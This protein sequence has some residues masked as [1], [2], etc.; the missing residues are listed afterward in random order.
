MT[1]TSDSQSAADRKLLA[2]DEPVPFRVLNP[3]SASRLLLLCD[4]A[5]RRI[6]A[7]LGSM[8]LDPAA[9]RC[10]LAWDIGAGA[11]TETLAKRL[12]ATAVL[13]NYSRLVV[14]CNRELLDPQAFLE[15]GDGVVIH[16]NRG[17]P[18]SQK[19][20]R[21]TEIFWPYHNAIEGQITRLRSAGVTPTILAIHSFTPVMNGVSRP[22]EIGILWDK[23]P[24][25][26]DILIPALREA[27]FHVGDNEPYTG[28]GPQDYTIDNHAEAALLPHAG[29]EVRQD[30][31][32]HADGVKRLGD[33][34][35]N[36]LRAALAAPGSSDASA[37]RA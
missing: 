12:K 18:Q 13:C 25:V 31:I 30:L 34:F 21:A 1:H 4:H 32:A 5:S 36:V 7:S 11:L 27:G 19:D 28:R 17:L 35:E 3:E 26:P 29:I 20:A 37:A 8:G 16:G 9:L 33:A 14:D 22:W 24:S 2:A 15:Y 10:H 23:D 6:P